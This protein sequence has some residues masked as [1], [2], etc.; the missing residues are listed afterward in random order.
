M[1]QDLPNSMDSTAFCLVHAIPQNISCCKKVS[2]HSLFNI[3]MQLG[4]E[5]GGVLNL[6][7]QFVYQ[8]LRYWWDI[9]DMWHMCHQYQLHL[10]S[11]SSNRHDIV[12]TIQYYQGSIPFFQWLVCLMIAVAWKG[13]PPSVSSL[14][15]RPWN[16]YSLFCG[17]IRWKSYTRIN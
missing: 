3:R 16:P 9:N 15:I 17:F 7:D 5:G 4:D 8:H 10:K 11:C 6:M 12:S 1:D 14:L 2:T 13:D